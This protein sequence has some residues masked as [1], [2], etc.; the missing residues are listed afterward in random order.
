MNHDSRHW[1]NRPHQKKVEEIRDRHL[2]RLKLA[3]M[4]EFVQKVN[5]QDAN[6]ENLGQG[7]NAR[8]GRSPNPDGNNIARYKDTKASNS[9]HFYWSTKVIWE[10]WEIRK[11]ADPEM[12]SQDRI[13][14]RP[15]HYIQAELIESGTRGH[16]MELHSEGKDKRPDSTWIGGMGKLPYFEAGKGD[17]G[18]A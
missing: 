8:E 17:V 15:Y 5:G 10:D 18:M 11:I 4:T 6:L 7:S 3:Y 12:A 1:T 13:L 2:T 14:P 9:Q 16:R